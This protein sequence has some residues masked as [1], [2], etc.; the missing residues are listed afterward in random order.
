MVVVG[1]L[2]R[3][4]GRGPWFHATSLISEPFNLFICSALLPY[5]G[6]EQIGMTISPGTELLVLCAFTFI[7]FNTYYF[8][9]LLSL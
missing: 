5:S 8:I 3:R 1:G 7:L 2:E 9:K 6:R 4:K